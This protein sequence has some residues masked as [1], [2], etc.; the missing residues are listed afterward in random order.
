LS[1]CVSRAS[2]DLMAALVC[3]LGDRPDLP[4][5]E[6]KAFDAA[7]DVTYEALSTTTHH[8]AVAAVNGLLVAGWRLVSPDGVSLER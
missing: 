7:V 4:A 3:D 6:A 5:P 1:R 2:H 8:A